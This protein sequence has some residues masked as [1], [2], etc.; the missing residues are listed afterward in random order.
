MRISPSLATQLQVSSDESVKIKYHREENIPTATVVKYYLEFE[1]QLIDKSLVE[2][3]LRKLP[4]MQASNNYVLENRATVLIYEVEFKDLSYVNDKFIAFKTDESTKFVE[5]KFQPAKVE[6]SLKHYPTSSIGG[7]DSQKAEIKKIMEAFFNES[8]YDRPIFSN[9]LIIHGQ[10]G[11]GKTTLVHE[12][13]SESKFKS[14]CITPRLMSVHQNLVKSAEKDYLK[15]IFQRASKTASSIIFIDDLDIIC[16][17]KDH[18]VFKIN[19][20]NTTTKIIGLIDGLN[21]SKSHVFIISTAKSVEKIDLALRRPGRF[22][23]DIEIPVPDR[24]QR[25]KIMEKIINSWK[26]GTSKIS[27]KF[28]KKLSDDAHGFV[29]ADLECIIKEA[30]VSSVLRS[31]DENIQITDDDLKESF[32]LIKP[33]C[34]R[35][36]QLEVPKIQWDDIGGQDDT[37]QR[38][39]EYVEWPLKVIFSIIFA[40]LIKF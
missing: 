19:D 35:D 5:N 11:C 24:F 21:Q 38:L 20:L 18:S 15:D 34:V 2:H 36:I 6:L 40:A 14:F 28:I 39:R 23:F 32:I 17:K 13:L 12:I 3:S 33:S 1:S 4:V 7:L 16:P 29:G 26:I 31:T 9:G 10:S 22:T 25:F 27:R 8:N 30:S 37:K